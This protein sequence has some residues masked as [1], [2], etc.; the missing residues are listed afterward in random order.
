MEI[1]QN[2]GAL[3]EYMN[4]K[5]KYIL[6]TKWDIAV[7]IQKAKRHSGLFFKLQQIQKSK[8]RNFDA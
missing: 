6:K 2:F 8:Q 1:L 7:A 4:F 3:S 5:N